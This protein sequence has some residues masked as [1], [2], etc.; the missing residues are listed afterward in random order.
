MNEFIAEL[1]YDTG[2]IEKPDPEELDYYNELRTE[3]A[4]EE[5]GQH[6]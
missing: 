3:Q 2:T 1:Y 6:E 4:L 5:R